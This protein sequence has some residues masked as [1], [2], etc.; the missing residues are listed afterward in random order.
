MA[1]AAQVFLIHLVVIAFGNRKTD[2]GPGC[3]QQGVVYRE[4]DVE[5]LRAA[6]LEKV[7]AKGYIADAALA[8]EC[9]RFVP[10][11]VEFGN[12]VFG[13][14]HVVHQKHARSFIS[15]HESNR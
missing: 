15:C 10:V 11:T 12:I 8:T 3:T 4:Q 5:R 7:A 13:D 14:V 2:A 9:Q 6:A 1:V